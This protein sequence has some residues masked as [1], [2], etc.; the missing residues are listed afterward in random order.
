MQHH[1]FVYIKSKDILEN[2]LILDGID[3]TN[4][5]INRGGN[6]YFHLISRVFFKNLKLFK[7]MKRNNID[8]LISAASDSSQSSFLLGIPSIILNDDDANVI[9]KSAIF[10]WPF[11]SV[12][13][14]PKSCEM[15]YWHRKTIFYN[16]YQKLAYLHPKYFQTDQN[17]VN[18]YG[19]LGETFFII[20]SVSLTAHHDKNIRGLNSKLVDKLI[21]ILSPHGKVFISSEKELPP[22]LQPYKLIINPLD[23][24][25]I[26]SFASLLVGD[27]QSMSHEAALL[28]TPSIRYNDFVGKIGVLEELEHTH[29]LA[30]GISPNNP[31]RLLQKTKE[32][33]LSND[34]TVFKKRATK[35]IQSMIDLPLF[36]SWFIDNFPV[37]K[38]IVTK[39]PDILN[40]FN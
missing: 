31:E 3:Y 35:V 9:R 26:I 28:G 10:G 38:S 40:E 20:R 15:G 21:K 22:H 6:N 12:I 25:H 17:I 34:K 1:I 33:A 37:S 16:G 2:L 5:N 7:D 29:G 4:I 8:I 23:I 14:A 13:L 36:I 39:N 30:L 24:H 11:S 18:R 19:L 27:S 32:I